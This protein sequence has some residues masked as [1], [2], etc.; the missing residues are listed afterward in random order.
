MMLSPT[1]EASVTDVAMR[2]RH[3]SLMWKSD[4]YISN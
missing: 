1:P 3:E 4:E 2:S